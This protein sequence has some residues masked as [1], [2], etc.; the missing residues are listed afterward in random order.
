MVEPMKKRKR[1]DTGIDNDDEII[2]TQQTI[3]E[4]EKESE[5]K[6]HYSKTAN[7]AGMKFIEL[8]Q[9]EEMEGE[10]L[11]VALNTKALLN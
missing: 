11:Y 3:E 8:D 9:V 2:T 10:K 5:I 1:K 4:F 6:R 7:G